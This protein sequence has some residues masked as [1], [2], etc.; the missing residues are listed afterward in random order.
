[1]NE[2]LKYATSITLVLV[3]VACHHQN[4]PG[5]ILDG[6]TCSA[7]YVSLMEGEMKNQKEHIMPLDSAL[8]KNKQEVFSRY[9]TTEDEFRTT[10]RSYGS[11]VGKW[12]D[13]YDGVVRRLESES[14]E[15]N[16]QAGS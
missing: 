2:K 6:E 15:K 1:M 12:K 8:S 14:K 3:A 5:K 13:L 4:Q 11:D 16:Q 10:L 9:G 7:I